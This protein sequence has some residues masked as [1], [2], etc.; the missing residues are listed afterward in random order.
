[1]FRHNTDHS[2]A[3]RCAKVARECRK[4][5]DIARAIKLEQRALRLEG[6]L[7]APKAAW[8]FSAELN[9]LAVS[10]HRVTL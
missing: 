5:G 8:D 2:E 6:Y 7:A 4:S 10:R 1:M 9:Q 3:V